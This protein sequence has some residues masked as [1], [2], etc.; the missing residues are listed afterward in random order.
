MAN[1][2]QGKSIVSITDISKDEIEEVLNLAR[3]WK[4]DLPGKILDGRIMASLFFEASTRTRFSFET[5]MLRLGGQVVH[6]ENARV[7]TS[8]EKG[9]TIEDTARVLDKLVDVIVMR[10]HEEGYARRAASV[11]SVPIINA[12]DGPGE[13]PTQT[14]IDLY[15]I[16]EELE[17]LDNIRIA[18]VG[19]LLYG[20]TVRSLCQA[21]ALYDGIEIYFV[22]PRELQM[23]EDIKVFLNDHAIVFSE[24]YRMEDVLDKVDVLYMTRI[25]KERFATR[26]DYE[27]YK[28]V[29]IFNEE[30][31]AKIRDNSIIMHP[32]PRVGEI[33]PIV[34]KDPRAVYFKQVQNGLF[35]R[36]AI[37]SLVL[38]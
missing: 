23:R 7:F 9:E 27:R 3:I 28:G 36:M 35:I 1:S 17:H 22:S 25:Q 2:L 18:M 29:Y 26:E 12:G 19:D 34:D 20:R 32:L 21:L 33:D 5:A 31:L 37:L 16:L 6:S 14:L 13:H 24:H 8:T 4:Q 38:E 11:S 15:T 10:S 30:S